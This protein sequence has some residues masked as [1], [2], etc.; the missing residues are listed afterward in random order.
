[1]NITKFR[2]K[3]KITKPDKQAFSVVVYKGID[4]VNSNNEM[5]VSAGLR[6]LKQ[7]LPVCY[8]YRAH[9]I[10]GFATVRRV[11]STLVAD[12]EIDPKYK[13]L[14]PGI[15]MQVMKEHK[16]PGS[17]VRVIDQ[18]LLAAIGLAD[19]NIDLTMKPI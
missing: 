15:G 7:K 2:N 5:I 16:E 14:I 8:K 17:T 11:D 13:G 6:I 12:F 1:M 9:N 19:S 3:A 18:C 10:L 4:A